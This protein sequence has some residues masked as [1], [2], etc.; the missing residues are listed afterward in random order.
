[1]IIFFGTREVRKDDPHGF[2][3]TGRCPACGNVV[4]LRPRQAR[5][6]F[7]LFWIPLIPLQRT[8][9]RYLECPTCKA[10][11]TTTRQ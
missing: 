4:T 5:L 11:F 2:P 8:P 10:R 6:Y 3:Q 7:H 1:M 9:Q